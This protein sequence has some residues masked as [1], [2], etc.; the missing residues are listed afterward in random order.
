ML[1][2]LP[3][4]RARLDR[5][6]VPLALVQDAAGPNAGVASEGGPGGPESAAFRG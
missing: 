6:T 1:G 3:F 4:L 2:F 5:E